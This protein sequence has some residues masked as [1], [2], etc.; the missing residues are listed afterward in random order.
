MNMLL[1]ATAGVGKAGT[2]MCLPAPQQVLAK[3]IARVVQ[4][5]WVAPGDALKELDTPPVVHTCAGQ[6]MMCWCPAS[7][8][9]N[10]EDICGLLV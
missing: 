1:C 7:D 10:P 5:V 9:A 4:L 2:R 6:G 3:G 8:D